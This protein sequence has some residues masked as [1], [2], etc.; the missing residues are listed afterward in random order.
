MTEHEPSKIAKELT[1][2]ILSAD[3]AVKAIK[4]Q[5]TFFHE[6]TDLLANEYKL[7]RK[8]YQNLKEIIRDLKEGENEH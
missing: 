1:E 4:I 6:Q 8:R 3:Q 2:L 5:A 7:L